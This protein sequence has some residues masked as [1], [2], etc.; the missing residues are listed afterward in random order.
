MSHSHFR[1]FKNASNNSQS[2]RIQTEIINL[3]HFL[4]RITLFKGLLKLKSFKLFIKMEIEDTKFFNIFENRF[5]KEFNDYRCHIHS[6]CKNSFQ[7]H[8]HH[9]G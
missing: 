9:L 7:L 2:K 1:S 6:L 4:N 5:H 3:L 8:R